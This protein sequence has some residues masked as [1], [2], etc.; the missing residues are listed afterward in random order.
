MK[1]VFILIDNLVQLYLWVVIINAILSWL[2]AFKIINT[3]NK[4]VYSLIEVSY[5]LTEPLLRKIK[6]VVPIIAGI[7]FSP[8]I[9]IL[10]LI[11]LRNLIFEFFAPSLF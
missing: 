6:K 11:F 5:N 7:D 1:S 10:L 8:V 3:S 2:V 9:L 4:F